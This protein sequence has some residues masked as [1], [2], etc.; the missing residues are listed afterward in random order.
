MSIKITSCYDSMFLVVKIPFL[1]L[2]NFQIILSIE[3]AA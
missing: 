2:E 1:T 3:C